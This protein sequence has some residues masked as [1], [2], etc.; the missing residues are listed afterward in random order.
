MRV[1]FVSLAALMVLLQI[2]CAFNGNRDYAV[3]AEPQFV[4]GEP[5]DLVDI[6][7]NILSIPSKVLMWDRRVDNHD[8]SMETERA[9]ENYVVANGLESTK[10]RFNQYD[11]M[12]EWKRLGKNKA[13]PP[14][15]R[16]TFG[17]AQTLAYT[18]CPGR[19]FGGDKYNPYTDTLNVYSDI[20]ALG[21]AEVAYAKNLRQREHRGWYTFGQEFPLIGMHHE[22]QAT[23][24]VLGYL[25]A[26]GDPYHQKEGVEI[27]YPRYGAAWGTSIGDVVGNGNP[28]GI[29]A[30]SVVGHIAG[31]NRSKKIEQVGYDVP[32][33]IP[34]VR[35]QTP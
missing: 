29:I 23:Q 24:D 28:V 16:Y 17:A 25:A 10:V 8:V 15:M 33:F 6:P 2:G 20:P 4:R 9:I 22:G 14:L 13:I 21:M 32:V 11:P 26:Q 34:A 31:R 19:L 12:G 27:L 3:I 1:P 30:G 18:V 35:G 5:C 7:A